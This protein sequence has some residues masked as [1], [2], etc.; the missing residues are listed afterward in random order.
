LKPQYCEKG[1][2]AAASELQGEKQCDIKSLQTAPQSCVDIAQG[3]IQERANGR[4]DRTSTLTVQK[5]KGKGCGCHRTCTI[6]LKGNV[7]NH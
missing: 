5:C 3:H 7:F 6:R 4:G 1:C 2:V